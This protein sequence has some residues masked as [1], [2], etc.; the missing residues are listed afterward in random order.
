[1]RIIRNQLRVIIFDWNLIRTF[2]L[3]SIFV[4]DEPQRYYLYVSPRLV[5]Q[6]ECANELLDAD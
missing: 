1:M 2:L 6:I 5:A 3:V 4:N